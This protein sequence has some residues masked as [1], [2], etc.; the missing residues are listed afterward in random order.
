MHAT[1]TINGKT[2]S[3]TSLDD[4]LYDILYDLSMSSASASGEGVALCDGEPTDEAKKEIYA[5]YVPSEKK[6]AYAAACAV[7]KQTPSIE[8]GLEA[9]ANH[10]LDAIAREA[11]KLAGFED[12]QTAQLAE[13]IGSQAGDPWWGTGMWASSRI[14]DI[15]QALLLVLLAGAWAGFFTTVGVQASMDRIKNYFDI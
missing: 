9:R 12:D 10:E 5:K 15:I 4:A 1:F 3:T 11:G 14:L 6:D 13:L 2:I 8:E 7:L